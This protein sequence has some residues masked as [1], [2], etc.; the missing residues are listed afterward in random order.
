MALLDELNKTDVYLTIIGKLVKIENNI[1]VEYL[2]TK[3]VEEL[4]E[5]CLNLK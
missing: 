3:T 2:Q 4:K 1:F 5:I